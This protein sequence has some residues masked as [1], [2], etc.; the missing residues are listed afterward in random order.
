MNRQKQ[1]ASTIAMRLLDLRESSGAK[2]KNI[3]ELIGT[4]QSRMSEYEHGEV[5]PSLFSLIKLA[6][7]YGVSLDYIVGRTDR[8][9]MCKE[10][11]MHG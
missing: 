2:Q 8:Q 9:K 6:D 3:A 11:I 1:I 10:E 5:L 7:T 4:S